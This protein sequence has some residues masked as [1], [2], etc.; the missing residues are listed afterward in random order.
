M[1]AVSGR[2]I[3]IPARFVTAKILTLEIR[4]TPMFSIFSSP[5]R[6][7]RRRTS[8]QGLFCGTS[9]EQC[10]PLV[11]LSARGIATVP[12]AVIQ[13]VNVD[14]SEKISVSAKAP[15]DFSGHW[16]LTGSL[17]PGDLDVNQNGSQVS[18]TISFDQEPDI[19]NVPLEGKVKG[20][21]LKAQLADSPYD[22]LRKVVFKAKLSEE[23]D[24]SWSIR[25]WDV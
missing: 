21:K 18:L 13:S 1:I 12:E 20:R 23:G 22:N 24:I 7:S 3:E 19:T 15:A 2:I 5:F 25:W 9:V 8:T 17:G 6:K 10:E 11:L 4:G 14:S 16:P